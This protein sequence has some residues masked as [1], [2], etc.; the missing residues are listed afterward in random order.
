MSAITLAEL[1]AWL[2]RDKTPQRYRD[3]LSSLSAEFVVL[4]VDEEVA[5][6]FGEISARL[7]D[8]GQPIAT[9]DLL[10]AAT[11]LVHDL[12]LV[13]GNVRHFAE[14]DGLRVANWLAD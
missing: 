11:A 1:Q 13:T 2:H 3:A 8:R 9:P 6:R 14:I 12:T 10:I 4:P 7:L 5:Q